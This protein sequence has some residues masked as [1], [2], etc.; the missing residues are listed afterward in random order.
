MSEATVPAQL[1]WDFIGSLTETEGYVPG[2]WPEFD[3]LRV[4]LGDEDDS[5]EDDS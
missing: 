5:L 4:A 1:V 2:E 3:A